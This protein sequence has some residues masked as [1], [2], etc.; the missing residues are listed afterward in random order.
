MK[1]H[2]QIVLIDEPD[3]YI[4]VISFYDTKTKTYGV[5]IYY[6]ERLAETHNT[7]DKE[8]L[9]DFLLSMGY[10]FIITNLNKSYL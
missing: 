8:P 3:G 4:E 10:H 9:R 1:V 7:M 5:D 6:E 2:K